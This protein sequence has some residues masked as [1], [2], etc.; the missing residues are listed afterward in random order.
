LARGT[1]LPGA[2]TVLIET[3]DRAAGVE[4]QP[5]QVLTPSIYRTDGN[6]EQAQVLF[7]LDTAH[8]IKPFIIRGIFNFFMLK[9]PS[10]IKQG[11][12]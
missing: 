9:V 7:H 12:G 6:C 3:F 4:P 8:S 10:E 11:A 5:T 1:L 2:K